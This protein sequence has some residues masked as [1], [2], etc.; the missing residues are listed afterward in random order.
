MRQDGFRSRVVVEKLAVLLKSSAILA[1]ATCM[2][3]I[4][5]LAAAAAPEP[6]VIMIASKDFSE[7]S[8][9]VA[10]A[11]EGQLSDLAV[12]FHVEWVDELREGGVLDELLERQF[13]TAQTREDLS[14]LAA[15]SQAEL[16]EFQAAIQDVDGLDAAFRQ[17]VDLVEKLPPKLK[18]VALVP[19]AVLPQGRLL[20]AATYLVLGAY[21][22]LA[23]ADYLDSRRLQLLQRV[24]GVRQAVE[25]ALCAIGT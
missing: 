17:Q 5:V 10:E 15:R 8:M 21:V 1:A 16:A 20:L 22:I 12:N 13:E 4:P 2:C 9:K 11:I 7:E 19:A 24:P 14:R 23:G 25:A 3:A 18:Y 6:T